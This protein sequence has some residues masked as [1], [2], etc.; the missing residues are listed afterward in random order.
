MSTTSFSQRQTKA[1]HHLASAHAGPSSGSGMLTR[2]LSSMA[3][4]INQ[5]DRKLTDSG[6]INPIAE[7]V[8]VVA[9]QR[10]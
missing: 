8:S 1:N 2:L 10:R 3:T 9:T 4:L 5:S 6:V 7:R